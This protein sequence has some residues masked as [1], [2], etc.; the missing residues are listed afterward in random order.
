MVLGPELDDE[1]LR[2]SGNV[3][4]V[5]ILQ[6]H[7]NPARREGMEELQTMAGQTSGHVVDF[8]NR[9][10]EAK[11]LAFA[12]ALSGYDHLTRGVEVFVVNE[13]KDDEAV[14]GIHSI[15]PR[16]AL[17]EGHRG[18]TVNPPIHADILEDVGASSA[19]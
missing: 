11:D 4:L 17:T 9:D 14:S 12:V 3:G 16:G 10:S 1:S 5:A 18:V 8:M 15:N 19:N 2:I 6:V 7:D 13:G